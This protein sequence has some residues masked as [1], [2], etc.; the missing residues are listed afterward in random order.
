MNQF[1]QDFT[2]LKQYRTELP[3]LY[4][5]LGLDVFEFRL[6]AH[7]KR[8]GTCTEATNTTA[9][10]CC[11]SKT[12]VIEARQSL[13]KRKLIKLEKVPWPG[14]F[15]YS[16][17]VNDIW[18]ENYAKYSGL[19]PDE[20]INK[21]NTGVATFTPSGPNIDPQG[22]PHGLKEVSTSS[23]NIFKT[24]EQNIGLLTPIISETLKDAENEYP[25]EW[26]NEAFEIC[27]AQNKRSW[28]YAE[29]ILKRWKTE[30]KDTGRG[31]K[32]PAEESRPE[33]RKLPTAAEEEA[34]GN[35]LKTPPKR[36]RND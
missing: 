35:Y 27:V 5:D 2:D 20:I 29:T 28:A 12:K 17:T 1:I 3:N 11:M 21:V 13:A 31:G 9:E 22:S 18:V 24:Y 30:G 4:D 32:K 25:E 14:G 36:K 26:I 8:V 23:N 7:Y 19:R 16:V 34:S 15:A 33:Y 6:L 10:K